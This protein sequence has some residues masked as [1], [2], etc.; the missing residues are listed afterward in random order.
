M[1][2]RQSYQRDFIRLF[3]DL[4]CALAAL[5]LLNL[6]DG[7]IGIFGVVSSLIGAYDKWS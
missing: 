6:N 7:Y 5:Q 2:N 1:A 3:A 4:L